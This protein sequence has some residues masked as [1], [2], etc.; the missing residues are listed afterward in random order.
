M[1][2]LPSGA[3]RR[4]PN[5]P[6]G[7]TLVELL[8]VV[9]IIGVLLALTLPAV[10][11][12][13]EAARRTRCASNLKQIGVALQGHHEAYGS[14][15]PGVPS[16]TAET[17]RTG[18]T[19]AGCIC[20]GPNWAMNILAQMGEPKMFQTV[21]ECLDSPQLDTGFNP[22]DDTEHWGRDNGG[23]PTL[24]VGRWTPGCYL[25]PSADVMTHQI[26]AASTVAGDRSTDTWEH[27]DGTTKGNYAG[28][29][30]SDT[31]IS[32]LDVERGGKGLHQTAGTLPVVMLRTWDRP[33]R[34]QQEEHPSLKGTWKMGNE[35]G[36]GQ[37]EIR[38]GISHTLMVSEVLGYDSPYDA[39]GGWV[40]AAPGSSTFTA[41]TGPNAEQNDQ[42]S[43]CYDAHDPGGGIPAGHP[44]HCTENRLDGEL[45]AAARSAHIG[46]VNAV[47]ADGSVHFFADDVQLRVWQAL[48]TRCGG[49]KAPPLE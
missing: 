27:D 33:D 26:G 47:L 10:Q 39:R 6:F 42:V 36:V 21:F 1:H 34:V 5:R 46:G 13:R 48:A 23:D 37:V 28:C 25:C 8:V 3:C 35:Q 40:I 38:D 41:K 2:T 18:G 14:F 30:G 31:Y 24:N 17:W 4:L 32:Y 12:A 43:V 22:S 19:Q 44:L 7:F 29:L 16:C 15:P 9:A 45:W 49:E 20:Q 11:A